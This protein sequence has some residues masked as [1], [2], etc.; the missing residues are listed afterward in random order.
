MR[1]V[2]ITKTGGPEVLQVR[3]APDP[4]PKPGEV[5]IRVAAAGVNFADVLARMGLYPD[6][7]PLPA[8]V[9][10]EVAGVVDRVGAGVRG[11]RE[12]DRVGALTRF[13]GYSDTVCV[14][15][16]QATPLPDR[17]SFEAAAA[18]PVNY[19]T[20]WIMLVHLGNVHAGE[21]VLVHAAAGGVGQAAI[22][23]C[24]WRGAEVIGTASASKHARLRE[25]GVA[26]CIDYTTQDFEAEV[27]RIT[28]GN[29]VDIALD[30]VGGESFRKSYRSLAHL[31]RLYVFGVS[32]FAPGRRRSIPAALKG[33]LSIPRF[34]PIAMMNANRGVHGV[35]LGH[36]W[37]RADLLKQMQGEI[38]ALV[39][40]GTFTPVVD[41]TFP[42]ERAGEAHAYLQDRRNFGKVLLT[43]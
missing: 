18:I 3:E 5:R 8:V 4:E 10:Y 2:W 17:L 21:R 37:H 12:G 42:L 16:A 13:G 38:M 19:L 25:A 11:I 24:R 29:G 33:M 7:P 41:Q 43:P 31:G 1:Q 32:S 30:A 15:E 22:Q 35:N 6:A 34:H 23:I 26:H 39:D 27:K 28:G 9:G 40:D 36:L 14:T 20:A